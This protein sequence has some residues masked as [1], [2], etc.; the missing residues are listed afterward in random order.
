MIKK[1]TNPE[2]LL[3]PGCVPILE[4]LEDDDS[5]LPTLSL[6]PPSGSLISDEN[7]D[8]AILRTHL[9]T[10]ASPTRTFLLPLIE[11]A[12]S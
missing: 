3:S 11:N 4:V 9:R 2:L 10:R 7:T 12:M 8:P 6:S 1:S 5:V